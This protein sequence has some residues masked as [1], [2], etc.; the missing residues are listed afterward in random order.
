[1]RLMAF[2]YGRRRIGIAVGDGLTG[3][4]RGLVTLATNHPGLQERLRVLV[5]EWRPEAFVVGWPTRDDGQPTALGPA[6]R[7]FGEALG[8]EFGLPVY[9]AD[10]RLSSHLGRERIR[11]RGRDPGLDAHAA[12]V[13][14]EGWLTENTRN[15]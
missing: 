5:A 8:R 7:G 4:A 1:M 15:A 12:A 2:D 3:R 13:I 9:W 14:L 6:I 10:E 11:R